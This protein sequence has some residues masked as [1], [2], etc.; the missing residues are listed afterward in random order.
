MSFYQLP[1]LEVCFGCTFFLPINLGK[2]WNYANC[3]RNLI[4]LCKYYFA[5]NEWYNTF[6]DKYISVAFCNYLHLFVWIYSFYTFFWN[7]D[8]TKK[9]RP[10]KNSKCRS[11]PFKIIAK[12]WLIVLFV[13]IWWPSK[14]YVW[15]NSFIKLIN[16]KVL[17]NY[18]QPNYYSTTYG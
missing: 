12:S 13:K 11:Q 4:D 10:N 7:I 3:D 5:E 2:C 14:V 9:S 15:Q 6:H 16:F 1:R 17:S 18:I 8:R